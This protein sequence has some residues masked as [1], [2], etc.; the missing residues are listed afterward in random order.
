MPCTATAPATK[1]RAPFPWFGGKGRASPLVWQRFGDVENYVDTFAGSLA[2]LLA[3]PHWDVEAAAWKSGSH[4][5]ETVNDLDCYLTNFWR[6]VTADPAEVARWADY[7]VSEIDLHARHR[8]LWEQQDFRERM[9]EDPHHFNAKI[10]GWWVWGISAWV[11]SEWCS[12]RAHRWRQRPDLGRAGT[13]VHAV[14]LS[15][16]GLRGLIDSLSARLR[17]VRIACGDWRRV[18]TRGPLR[19]RRAKS[20]GVFLDPPYRQDERTV[21]YSEDPADIA[22]DVGRWALQNGSD[23]ALRIAVCGL[24]GEHTA[25]EAAGWSVE[26]WT[27]CC[28]YASTARGRANAG[29][30]RIWFSPH[31]LKPGELDESPSQ[32]LLQ[33][34]DMVGH[35]AAAPPLTTLPS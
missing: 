21:R 25:L 30:E 18:L 4:R 33:I 12:E 19:L 31:C 28:G 17:P 1:L 20:I 26:S 34:G 3:R 7:P 10:A 32:P 9:R 15:N 5:V 13:G 6:A 8:W 29:R 14:G 27:G 23:P 2:V 11:G 16:S 22:S 35:R 24:A